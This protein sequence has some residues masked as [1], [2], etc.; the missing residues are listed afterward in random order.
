MHDL[1]QSETS[2]ESLL[3]L[4][5]STSVELGEKTSEK[6][7]SIESTKVVRRSR[8]EYG[9]LHIQVISN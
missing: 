7:V 8:G 4:S 6:S 2:R 3:F 5:F 1:E 9:V